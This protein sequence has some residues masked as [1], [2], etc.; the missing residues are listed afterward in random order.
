MNHF[1]LLPAPWN[2]LLFYL[3]VIISV[4]INSFSSGEARI[5]TAIC[6]LPAKISHS[7]T[8]EETNLLCSASESPS[9]WF[10]ALIDVVDC[11][12]NICNAQLEIIGLPYLLLIKSSISCEMTVIPNPYFLA[13]FVN[14]KRN[15]ADVSCWNMIHASSQASILCFLCD[16]TLVQIQLS[17][18]YIAGVFNASSKSLILMTV[19][20]LLISILV[21]LLN[22]FPNVQLTYLLNLSASLSPPSIHSKTFIRSS[23]SGGLLPS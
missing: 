1:D 20:L 4:V 9:S 8:L 6:W 15:S 19:S 3:V 22:T 16:L 12:N 21:W 17:T 18:L 14:P 23:I 5:F 2:L 10:N 7:P 13:L 11:F